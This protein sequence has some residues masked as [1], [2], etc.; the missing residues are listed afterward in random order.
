MT[1]V[2]L[3]SPRKQHVTTRSCSCSGWLADGPSDLITRVWV[4]S[5]LIAML[6]LSMLWLVMQG[7]MGGM[8]GDQG[9]MGGGMGGQQ[10]GGFGSGGTIR[11]L[12]VLM[13]PDQPA[14]PA[15]E[16]LYLLRQPLT[17]QPN[18]ARTSVPGRLHCT[19]SMP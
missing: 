16:L 11:T 10:G 13:S 19:A 7:G 15:R 9:G 18:K 3:M 17:L 4:R 1:L 8:G 2:D 6:T 5:T 14:V 12:P